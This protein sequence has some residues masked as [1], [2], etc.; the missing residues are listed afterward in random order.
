GTGLAPG[1]R[2]PI[3]FAPRPRVRRRRGPPARP[4]PSPPSAAL[5]APPV[6]RPPGAALRTVH[7]TG[8]PFT[9]LEHRSPTWNLVAE[10]DSA[11]VYVAPGGVEDVRLNG[12][13][14]PGG[15]GS[16]G[17]TD[18]P[19]ASRAQRLI[20]KGRKPMVT[21]LTFR[22]L[23]GL[24]ALLLG[25]AQLPAQ[26]ADIHVPGDQPTIAAGLA[27]AQDGD[28]VLVADGTYREQNLD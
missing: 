12:S 21:R 24:S 11:R 28:T 19:A 15:G 25:M 4:S 17:L 18:A 26:A 6:R 10:G 5:L 14:P 9:Y 23:L 27:A 16:D 13:A 8:T 7:K 22:T 20:R 3:P 2:T 1:L